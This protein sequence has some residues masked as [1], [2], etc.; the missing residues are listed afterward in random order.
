VAEVAYSL[1]D[2]LSLEMVGVVDDFRPESCL[3]HAHLPV[4]D[5]PA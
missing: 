4:S 3:R 2:G 1:L 5:L